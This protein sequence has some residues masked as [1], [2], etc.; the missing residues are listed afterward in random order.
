[1][2]LTSDELCFFSHIIVVSQ[3]ISCCATTY[4]P[5]RF[6]SYSC[7]KLWW[8][9]IPPSSIIIPN[10]AKDVWPSCTLYRVPANKPNFSCYHDLGANTTYFS[11]IYSWAAL[12]SLQCRPRINNLFKYANFVRTGAS[13]LTL[14]EFHIAFQT[15][16]NIYIRKIKD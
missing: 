11:I 8:I 15:Q 13:K 7:Q 4:I 10:V 1:M 5:H 3:A 6:S 14:S 2:F 12:H 16:S 9:K